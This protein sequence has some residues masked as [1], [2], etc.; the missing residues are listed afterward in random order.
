MSITID[1]GGEGRNSEAWNINVSRVK[2]VGPEAGSPIERLIQARGD[3]LPFGDGSVREVIVE[4][5][6]FSRA[7]AFEVARVLAPGGRVRL[8]H[9]QIPGRDRHAAA[10]E[11]I[12]GATS[13]S[14]RQIGAQIY[15]ETIVVTR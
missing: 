4:R 15:Q 11:L 7:V 5:T 12:E 13:E 1:I 14:T 3:A 2:T 9:V 8:R 10:K 6:P